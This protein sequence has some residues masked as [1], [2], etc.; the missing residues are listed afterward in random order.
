[1]KYDPVESLPVLLWS[2]STGQ[3]SRFERGSSLP[4]TLGRSGSENLRDLALTQVFK[5]YD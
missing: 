2:N 1:M 4:L 3:T 5:G